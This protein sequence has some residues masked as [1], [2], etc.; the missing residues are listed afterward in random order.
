[1]TF[2]VVVK[3]KDCCAGGKKKMICFEHFDFHMAWDSC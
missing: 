3:L 1:M 2:A